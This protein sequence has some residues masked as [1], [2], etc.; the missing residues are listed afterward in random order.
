MFPESQGADVMT[1]SP[2]VDVNRMTGTRNENSVLFS[3]SNLQALAAGGQAPEDMPPGAAPRP[4][5]AAAA[6]P[7]SFGAAPGL[8]GPAAT[9]STEGS[10][11]IDIRAMASAMD[12]HDSD[13][14]VDDL[15]SIGGGGGFAPTLGAPV[16]V[17]P[18]QEKSNKLLYAVLGIGLI[19][20]L[21]VVGLVVVL[22]L[23]REPDPTPVATAP[24][25]V[26]AQPG[27]PTPAPTPAGTVPAAATGQPAT[28]TETPATAEGAGEL[29]AEG[30]EGAEGAEEGSGEDSNGRGK[31]RGS[32]RGSKS[33]GD[34]GE[35]AAPA[36]P[37]P[38]P[39]AAKATPAK[40]SARSKRGAN[41]LDSL[42]DQAIGS[43]PGKRPAKAAAPAAE[44][45]APA[46]GDSSIPQKLNRGQVSS[47]MNRVSGRV[48]RCGNGTTGRVTVDVVIS[49]STGRVSSVNVSGQFAGTPI[50]SCAARAVRGARFP[51]FRDPSL[52]VRGYPFPVR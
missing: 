1:S 16:L 13:D 38:G 20:V 21:C 33:P 32:R 42:L 26:L 39:A 48:A 4:M 40:G 49:G 35:A 41:D 8:A 50:G 43:T 46:G 37:A 2:R 14:G 27:A 9:G 11:L 44:P 6:G 30:A 31:R 12:S 47:G 24:Q 28:P 29:A 7:M 5:A 17:A 45:A 22:L 15:L 52:T 23:P 3:L 51:R 36:A 25:P 10:G 19:L 34:N 18:P